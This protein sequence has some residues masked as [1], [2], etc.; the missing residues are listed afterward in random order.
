MTA[1][2]DTDDD[3]IKTQAFRKHRKV[4]LEWFNHRLQL[5]CVEYSDA[6][7][8]CTIYP[9]HL[10]GVERMETWLTANSTVFVSLEKW[11]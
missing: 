7:D 4:P 11:R 1:G 3:T 2:Y 6:P 10:T 8:Q 9:P 5:T